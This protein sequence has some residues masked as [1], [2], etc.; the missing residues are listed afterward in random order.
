[1]V[2]C[3]GSCVKQFQRCNV[4]SNLESS[5]NVCWR[6][7]KHGSNTPLQC[8]KKDWCTFICI[9]VLNGT[10]RAGLKPPYFSTKHW[11]Q[12][13]IWAELTIDPLGPIVLDKSTAF[14]NYPFHGHKSVFG[15]GFSLWT[16]A[17]LAIATLQ[18]PI[19]RRLRGYLYTERKR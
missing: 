13:P 4:E 3:L 19:G 10:C 6:L 18:D 14:Q 1:M 15:F 5:K 8:T 17:L 12:I 2:C 9:V 7:L 11:R 16:F